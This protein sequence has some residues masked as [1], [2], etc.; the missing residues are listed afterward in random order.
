MIKKF[1]DPPSGATMLK[2]HVTPNARSAEN[3]HFWGYFIEQN[4]HLK[5]VAIQKSLDFFV[6]PYFSW[7]NFVTPPASLCP[8]HSEENDSPL[9]SF[10]NKQQ[11]TAIPVCISW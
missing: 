7:K 8:P 1:Y 10:H 6:T 2:K 11:W 4:F 9:T 5:F 3:M